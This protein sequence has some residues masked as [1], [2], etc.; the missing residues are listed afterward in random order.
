MTDSVAGSGTRARG[1][2]RSRSL[3]LASLQLTVGA[4]CAIVGAQALV[5]PH[6]FVSPP[7]APLQPHLALWTLAFLAAGIALLSVGAVTPPRRV[8]Y[9]GHAGA[10]VLL[11]VLASLQAAAHHWPDA[12]VYAA[13]AFGTLAG[14]W[15]PEPGS[16]RPAAPAAELL[17][18]AAELLSSVLAAGA[19]LAGL[20]LLASPSW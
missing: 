6:R 18:P 13:L 7:L 14:V 10:T 3:R 17:T 1:S 12:C 16:R 9:V 5:A 15:V 8:R 20:A 11:S 4:V 2:R 19:V